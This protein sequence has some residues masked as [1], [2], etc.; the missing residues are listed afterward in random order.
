MGEVY[1]GMDESAAAVLEFLAAVGVPIEEGSP[2]A[3]R[4]MYE[5]T[6]A[7][8][9]PEDLMRCDL[10]ALIVPGSDKFHATSAARY[11]QEC[12]PK[13]RYW[14]MPVAGQSEEATAKELL[15]FL[16]SV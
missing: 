7:S 14:D 6:R 16:G 3:A 12:L 9:E 11:L 4:E 5:A 15:E 13:S 2:Q 10:P 1:E 8:A